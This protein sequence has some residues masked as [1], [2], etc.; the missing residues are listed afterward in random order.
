MLNTERSALQLCG[1]NVYVPLALVHF[2]WKLNV[3]KK[4]GGGVISDFCAV[5]YLVIFFGKRDW[6]ITVFSIV[7]A[8]F[9]VR[10]T[11][12]TYESA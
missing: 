9:S 6:I 7:Q 1:L 11:S 12:M 5:L 4:R 2:G 3:K 8:L 10:S